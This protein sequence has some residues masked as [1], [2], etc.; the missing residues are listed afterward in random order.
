[1]P[2]RR[3]RYS[4]ALLACLTAS[5]SWRAA[6]ADS[7]GP[8]RTDA[9]R[10]EDPWIRATAPGQSVAG[11]FM[12]VVNTTAT[13]D[14]LLRAS[15]PLAEEVQMHNTTIDGGVIRMRPMVDGVAIPAGGRVEFKPRAL[16]LMLL[17]LQTP[18]TAGANVP[19]TFE[20]GRAGKVTASFRIEA[21]TTP[22]REPRR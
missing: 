13:E 10:I 12:A 2:H 1:M 17:G 6:A 3:S 19:V 16:H 14:R 15:S 9:I 7:P 8:A 11:G 5:A 20:F 18:L 21:I 22:P 4:L